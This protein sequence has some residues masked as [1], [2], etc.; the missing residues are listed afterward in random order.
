MGILQGT[1]I[2]EILEEFYAGLADNPDLCVTFG[3]PPG[4]VWI[5]VV[6]DALN[7]AW[8]FDQAAAEQLEKKLAARLSHC[9]MISLDAGVFVTFEIERPSV[10]QMADI[11]DEL[12]TDVYKL[13]YDYQFESD[14]DSL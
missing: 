9:Q 2:R 5:Q 12:F 13:S 4:D 14:M 1:K 10:I 7:M 6:R 8:P 11:L 3:I